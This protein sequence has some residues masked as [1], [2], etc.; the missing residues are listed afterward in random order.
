MIPLERT[1]L[2]QLLSDQEYAER[3]VPY[4]RD[5]YFSSSEA[6]TIFKLYSE[7]YNKFR[8][9]PQPVALRIKLDAHPGLSEQQAKAAQDALDEIEQT[10]VLDAS[11]N[12][13]LLQQTEEYCRERAIYCALQQSIRMMDDP[14]ASRHAIP[15][16]LKEALAVSFDTHIGHNF[17]ADAEKRYEFYHQPEK[18]LPFDL[19]ALNAMTKG[20]VPQ[21]TLNVVMA[22]TNVGKSLF[23]CHMAAAAVRM[24]KKV[25]Y[26]TLEMAEE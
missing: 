1:I 15:D 20:G 24:G 6:A 5:Q 4:L 7:F 26:I 13:W 18:R 3:V 17:F 19:A 21:K 22:G 10:P 25:L 12:D 2:R 9:V 11:Q 16:L 14:K 23:L 8:A